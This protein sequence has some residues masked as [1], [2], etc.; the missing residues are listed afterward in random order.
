M[1]Q[2]KRVLIIGEKP[3]MVDFSDPAIPPG[4]NADKVRAGLEIAM[5]R[6]R[7]RGIEPDL[8]LTSTEEAAAGEVATALETKEYDCV[9]VGAGLRIVPKMTRIFETVMN[10]VHEHAPRARLAFNSD[11]E[12]SAAAAE[13]QLGQGS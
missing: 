5:R 8:V 11:P 7:E 9:V 3:D 12:D 10:A 6:L 2:S 4:M 13:R 1:P